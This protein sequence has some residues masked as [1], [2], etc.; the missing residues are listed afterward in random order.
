MSEQIRHVGRPLTKDIQPA[1]HLLTV[2]LSSECAVVD[3]VIHGLVL[4]WC[5]TGGSGSTM[6]SLADAN[7]VSSLAGAALHALH[8]IIH[9]PSVLVHSCDDA[10]VCMHVQ[11][12]SHMLLSFFRLVLWRLR[13][14]DLESYITCVWGPACI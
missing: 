4:G 13:V 1:E 6:G 2:L 5:I 3:E 12:F 9:T 11:R 8:V 10:S 14:I 7:L